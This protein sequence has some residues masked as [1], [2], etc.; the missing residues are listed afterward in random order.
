LEVLFLH[1]IEKPWRGRLEGG[2]FVVIPDLA[3]KAVRK[4]FRNLKLA[5]C[6][7]ELSPEQHNAMLYVEGE[8]DDY[9]PAERK[10]GPLAAFCHACDNTSARLWP[11]HPL[12]T[13]DPWSGAARIAS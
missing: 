6:R 10:Q 3:G 1:D 7:I 9:T 8:L 4:A 13:D 12:A 5:K 2:Q 11:E